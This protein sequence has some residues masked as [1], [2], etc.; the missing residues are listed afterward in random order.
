MATSSSAQAST[1]MITLKYSG[2]AASALIAT[3]SVLALL[4]ELF[5]LWTDK[6]GT[7]FGLGGGYLSIVTLA[8]FAAL[9]SVGALL[10]YRWV[11]KD[12]A[13]QPDYIKTS[14]YSFITNAF[15]AAT[16]LMFVGITAQLISILLSSLLLIGTSTDI[17]ALYVGQFLPALISAAVVGFVGFCAFSILKGKNYSALMSIVLASLAGALL[18]ATLITVPIKAHSVTSSS[19]TSPYDYTKYL[20]DLYD[21]KN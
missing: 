4:G 16:V 8:V 3:L 15:F 14:A 18:L 2:A 7:V 11:T 13:K 12:V 19:S 21:L 20:Q 5:G 6:A 17:G 9:F 1:S 10:L